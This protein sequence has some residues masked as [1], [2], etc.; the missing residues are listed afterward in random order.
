MSFDSDKP[1]NSLPLLPP[2]HDIETHSILKQAILTSRAL[3]E[4]K[5]AGRALPKQEVLIDSLVLLEAKDSSEIE[6]IF[7]THDKLYQADMLDTVH[8]DPQTKEVQNYRVALWNGYRAMRKRALNT[9][10]FV[11]I[12]QT[13]K[14]N[15]NGVRKTSGTKI[16]NP[17]GEVIYTPPEGE[18]LL[19]DL[20]FNLEQFIHDNSDIDPLIK[21]AIIHY[22]FEAI[23]PFYDGNGRAGRIINLL[24]LLQEG[25][26]ETPV[27]FLSR[28]IIDNKTAYYKGLQN[29]TENQDWESWVL[30]M[31][32]AVEETAH[33]TVQRIES[34]LEVMSWF[35]E[36]FKDKEPKIHTKEFVE[37]LFEQPYVRIH[38]V[39]HV[40]SV[41][42]QTASNYLK[43][44][45]NINLLE[46]FK[47]QNEVIYINPYFQK[48]LSR[49]I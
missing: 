10:A 38:S 30:Y 18:K 20:L 40:L 15:N 34:I 16:K 19:R 6:N 32:K 8:H 33:K 4:L 12:V 46:S 41:S 44:L 48:E 36:K 37:H 28:Y 3:A 26:L 1:F 35:S 13:I 22:Q 2:K 43:K 5:L 7:T 9:N 24:Y 14:E 47:F 49:D 17:I 45:E 39:S 11:E 42:R 25:L 21:M 27:L 31:L 29:V 23:H